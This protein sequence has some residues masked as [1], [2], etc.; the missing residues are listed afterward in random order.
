MAS[1]IKKKISIPK[2]TNF[3]IIDDLASFR[4]STVALLNKMGFGGNYLEAESFQKAMEI[5]PGAKIQF[6]LCDWNLPDGTGF[7]LL[8]KIRLIPRYKETPFLMIT[9]EDA[10]SNVL[11]AISA[12]ASNYLIKPWDEKSF[13]E[14]LTTAWMKHYPS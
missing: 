10:I 1:K 6:F 9:T 5:I 11:D 8:K 12:G 3:L 4:S 14:A 2:N 13:V 7:D